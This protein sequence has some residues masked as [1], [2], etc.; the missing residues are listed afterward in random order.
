MMSTAPTAARFRSPNT[1][2]DSSPGRDPERAVRGARFAGNL[3]AEA[4]AKGGQPRSALTRALRGADGTTATTHAE[5]PASTKEDN[6]SSFRVRSPWEQQQQHSSGSSEGVDLG[7][8]RNL[9]EVYEFKETLG[10][11]GNGIVRLVEHRATGA[12]FACKTLPKVL[13]EQAGAVSAKKSADHLAAIK[14]EIEVM[15]R[16]RGTLNVAHLEQVFEDDE[17][18]HIVMEHCRGGELLHTLG[19]KHYSE[20][21][22]AS[23]MRA[24]M[25]TLAQCHSHHILHLDVKPGNFMLLDS[26]DTAPLKAIDF[27]LSQPFVPEQ[28][29]RD[30]LGLEGTPWFMAPEML[31]SSVTTAVDVWSAGVMAHQLLTGDFPFNDRRN[32]FR[33]SVN[34]IWKSILMDKPNFKRSCWEDISDEAKD[35]VAMLLEKDPKERP[36]AKEALS[37]PFLKSGTVEDRH[38]PKSKSLKRS[39]VQRIQRYGQSSLVKRTLLESLVAEMM[40]SGEMDA[41]AGVA[42]PRSPYTVTTPQCSTSLKALVSYLTRED[43]G[44]VSYATMQK[45]LVQLGYKLYPEELEHLME[46]MDVGHTGQLDIAQFVASQMDWPAVQK[47]HPEL[48]AEAARRTFQNLDT[49]GDGQV[50]VEDITAMLA[51][52]LPAAEVAPAVEEAAEQ[53]LDVDGCGKLDID[54]FMR[55]LR[56][57]SVDS[58]AELSMYDEKMGSCGSSSSLEGLLADL[59]KSY[60]DGS[61]HNSE[62][63]KQLEKSVKEGNLHNSAEW[64]QLEKSVKGGVKLKSLLGQVPAPGEAH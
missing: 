52:K 62:E 46:T 22:V 51:A 37:H 57:S 25:R 13:P 18:V 29:P 48:Y 33:P 7:Y 16:L 40:E 14:R 30:D 9:E 63:W 44:A 59:E 19:Q 54:G 56:C 39:V 49:N 17:S 45:L 42:C 35:F 21:T 3:L 31:S 38:S 34:A 8:A 10:K 60:R 53:V 50:C 27:G 12:T 43:G 23:V 1:Q 28:L 24:V 20:Q 4:N 41:S 58:L 36:S 15:R 6:A 5:A 61:L 2:R 32:P 26:S 11:G 55:L 64:K 47:A